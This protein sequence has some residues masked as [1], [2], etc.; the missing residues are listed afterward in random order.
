MVT[1]KSNPPYET[2]HTFQTE[3]NGRPIEFRSK[4]GLVD[5]NTV[6]PSTQLL[7]EFV[8][9]PAVGCSLFYGCGHGAAAAALARTA[10]L[11]KLWLTD[12]NYIALQMSRQTLDLNQVEHAFLLEEIEIPNSYKSNF[13]TVIIDLPKGRRLARRWLVQ[14]WEA[15]Q[16]GGLLYLAGSNEEGIQSVIRDAQDLCGAGT[17][18][19]YKKGN[20]I[21]RFVKAGSAQD[22]PD[23][24]Y[25]PGI[26]P[27]TWHEMNVTFAGYSLRLRS[28]PGIFSYDRLDAGTLFLL[29]N[30]KIPAGASL[31]D[32]GCGYGIIGLIGGISGAA[33]IDLIDAN[34]LAVAA[35][36]ENI[37][38]CPPGNMQA[39]L[40]DAL[41]SVQHRQYSMILTNP[42]FHAGKTVD[43]Q[44]AEA[45]IK[46]SWQQLIPEGQF[47]LVANRFIRYD[48]LMQPLFKRVELVSQNQGYRVWLGIK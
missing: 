33:K 32:L 2:V 26:A 34:L 8:S 35:A 30:I 7:A 28:L 18:L 4:P 14:G 31:L 21:S 24:A 20:R 3:L 46:Q 43:Y 47:A 40:S 16:I 12:V 37:A 6:R 48:Q 44:M 36:R 41:R 17:I 23:W 9:L 5:W 11:N 45:F 38:S 22:W 42:P 15:L 19:G 39:L 1:L 10:P 29:D 27:L 25:Q 13:S